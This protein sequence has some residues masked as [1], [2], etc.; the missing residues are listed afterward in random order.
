MWNTE[1]INSLEQY[2]KYLNERF[3]Y[4]EELKQILQIMRSYDSYR[5]LIV[6][7]AGCGKT[8]LLR[9]LSHYT[10]QKTSYEIL[11]SYEILFVV[12]HSKLFVYRDQ[13]ESTLCIDGLD[14][15]QDPYQILQQTNIQNQKRLICTSR[16]NI[17]NGNY[18]TH[19]VVFKPLT[20][21]QIK[22]LI[23][24]MDIS[25]DL[26]PL[27]INSLETT[28]LTPRDIFSRVLMSINDSNMGE[29]YSKYQ[30]LLYQH[31]NGLDFSSGII[32]PKKEL[33]VP[34]KGITTGI[35]IV[36]D[37][38]LK[39]A[40]QNPQ[41]MY[42]FSSR[43]FEQMV[44]E[45]LE[46]QGY[47]VNLTKQTR[48]GGKDIIILENSLVGQFCIYVECKKYSANNPISVKLVR[49]LYGTVEAEKA[50]AGMLI[51]TSY[52]SKDAKEFTEKAKH[53]MAL[54]DYNDLV[55]ELNKIKY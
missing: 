22:L 26:L 34:S 11:S 32:I 52:F 5:I 14:E 36:N 45:L 16:S 39:Q 19:M 18:F 13:N 37:T 25:I 10:S 44:C 30:N 55:Q 24:K 51:T 54:R 20:Q 29:F 23:E 28:N 9:M 40:Q 7:P 38:L 3:I 50:T 4:R 46:K 12:Q 2:E 49:E 33:I 43:E 41:I 53:R 47:K 8:T 35:T 31:G 42:S 6:G 21:N 15:I 17:S 1:V 27:L 48:D